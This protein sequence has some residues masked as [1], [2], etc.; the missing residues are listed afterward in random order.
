MTSLF[1]RPFLITKM[2]LTSVSYKAFLIKR[3]TCICLDLKIKTALKIKK[4][5]H[6]G[7]KSESPCLSIQ[8]VLKSLPVYVVSS[9][10]KNSFSSFT[11]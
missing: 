2:N 5:M 8:R 4:C 3:N 11:Y 9:S 1:E 10:K 6:A 7:C